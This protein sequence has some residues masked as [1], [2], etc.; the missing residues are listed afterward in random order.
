MKLFFLRVIGYFLAVS[1][2]D[3]IVDLIFY[4]SIE[5]TIL[6]GDLR[7]A[8]ITFFVVLTGTLI[9]SF[10]YRKKPAGNP[11]DQVDQQGSLH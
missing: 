11:G 2:L 8:I 7:S 9:I 1:V 5:S 6:G 3:V 4:Q 10:M